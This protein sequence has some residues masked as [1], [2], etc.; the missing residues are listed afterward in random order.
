MK[1]KL[2]P[3]CFDTITRHTNI[4]KVTIVYNKITN[5]QNDLRKDCTYVNPCMGNI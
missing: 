2:F 5:H 3:Y 1:A 4:Q